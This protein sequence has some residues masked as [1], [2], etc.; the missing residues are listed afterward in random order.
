MEVK[1]L[2]LSNEQADVIAFLDHDAFGTTRRVDTHAA[3]IF[4]TPDRA[5]KIKR[6]VNLGYL[7]FS[8]CEARHR[9]LEAELLLNRRTA[10][11][12][13]LGLHRI[14][15][16]REGAFE[17]DGEGDTVDWIL[18]M[19]RFPDDALLGHIAESGKLDLSMLRQLADT[20]QALHQD[21]EVMTGRDGCARLRE[22]MRG[23]AERL[24]KLVTVLPSDRVALLMDV[25]TG[26]L[27][28]HRNRLDAR[29]AAGRV[30]RG[31]G[32]S[33]LGNI[34]MVAGKPVLFDCLEFDEGLATTDV[35]YDL[36][37]LVMDLWHRGFNDEANI[38]CNRYLDR[39]A[40]DERGMV[41]MPFFISIRA[42]IRAHVA[43]TKAVEGDVDARGEA[44]SYLDLAAA[45]LEPASARLV[46]IG[47][48]S[49]TGKSTLARLLGGGI[50]RAPGARVLRSDVLRKRVAGIAP[51]AR[52]PRSSYTP[53]SA[54]QS[55]HAL[56]SEVAAHL[57]DGNSVIADAS[58]AELDERM[59]MIEVALDAGASFT[60]LWLEAPIQTRIMRVRNRRDDASDADEAVVRAQEETLIGDDEPWHI[61]QVDDAPD[62][63]AAAARKMLRIPLS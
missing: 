35:L 6:S 23:N 1:S 46:A 57:A 17:V 55:Y 52:L 4:L 22:V 54:T 37:F 13:Y 42:T 45:V 33:H 27:E 38:L 31:H 58:F 18:E 51:E 20:V 2:E 32:D 43:A 11:D 48:L 49:G 8:T 3:H 24:S 19:R 10:P 29:A 60:G 15:R 25:Q 21:A 47:G 44:L 36:A 53:A 14:T 62:V 63:V 50:G 59:A 56:R 39:S 16:T 12:L 7:D 9:A 61:L 30:R 5:W 40:A 41:L 28:K 34:A 26:L